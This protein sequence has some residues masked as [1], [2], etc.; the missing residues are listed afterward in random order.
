[1]ILDFALFF[2]RFFISLG[3]FAICFSRAAP[4]L[5]LFIRLSILI[6]FAPV[7]SAAPSTQAFPDI[8]FQVFSEFVQQSFSSKISLAT[9]LVLLFS[10]VENPELLS[11][12]ARQQHPIEG[13]NQ[14]VA[15]GWIKSLSRAIMHRLK[16]DKKTLFQ[17]GESY[18]K[19]SEQVTNLS[20]KLDAFATLLD[21][22]PYDEEGNFEK[23]LLPV[24]Y[25]SIQAVHTICP[26]TII[27]IDKK[28]APR[29]LL[30]ETRTRDVPLVTLIK[31]NVPYEDVPVLT[32][33]CHQCKATYHADHER[34]RDN[35]GLWN[36]C[37]LNSAR[38]LKIGKNTWADRGFTH[39]VL[40]G[41]YNFHAS[42]SA[43]T[44]FWNDCISVTSSEVQVTRR[45]VWQAFVQ[46][47]IRT[48]ASVQKI[49]LELREDLNIHEVVTQ[50]FAKLGNAGIIEPGRE[51]SCSECTQPHKHTADLISNEDPAAVIGAGDEH[52]AVP[53]LT[54]E[55]ADLSARE[56][57]RERNAARNRAN[58]A[59]TEDEMDV[60][61]ADVK[62]IVLDGVV[63]APTV[64]YIN[65]FALK[66]RTNVFF[67]KHCAYEKCT[68]DPKNARGGAFC[69][70]HEAFC[71]D[72]EKPYGEQCRI[73][74]CR[75]NRIADSLACQQ[76]Q[77]EWRK[78]KL[79]HSRT[80]MSGVK[81]MLQRPNERLNPWQPGLRRT[82]QRHDDDE[83]IE[84]PRK[85]YFGPA[86]FYCVETICAPCGVV[87]AWTK[88]DRSKSP[89][90]ILEFLESVYLTE[91]SRPAYICIDKACRVLRTAIANGSW[92]TWK[93]TTRFI[94]DAYHYIN[95][96]AL[97]YLCHKW[98][99]PAPLNGSAP[100]LIRIALDKSGR[101]YLQ[102]AFNTQV[103]AY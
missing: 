29:A 40:S 77:A 88:F 7:V 51:H 21:L 67:F 20:L 95:H 17:Q 32:G 18:L 4:S 23:K 74:K 9:V 66:M 50:A 2:Y 33:K 62:M 42:T 89:T 79:D 90:N 63:I 26:D 19:Q 56:T 59:N 94:V 45:L 8:S 71:K 5:P 69:K 82:E 16:D 43:Y 46:E 34:F 1:M 52:T 12:H 101:E 10:M 65:N 76:H 15:S 53:V 22:T 98:C 57:A 44:Q 86:K 85:H 38:F 73:V 28:C 64:N 97:D 83:D 80:S 39:S 81:R 100:N 30:Q 3:Y 99:N 27:C 25:A 103:C 78:Y 31:D 55:Y 37:Y 24:S 84:I 70:D 13:E 48:I 47:S 60:D 6:A 72:H 75:Q 92:N 91:E 35:H 54:G 96:R 87:I 58:R 102:R 14:T 36:K 49:N 68:K 93:K 61:A 41:V 11:L